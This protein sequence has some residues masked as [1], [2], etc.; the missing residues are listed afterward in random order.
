MEIRYVKYYLDSLELYE[1]IIIFFP[2]EIPMDVI[3]KWEKLFKPAF[4][5]L[6]IPTEIDITPSCEDPETI[7]IYLGDGW[8]IHICTST[9]DEWPFWSEKKFWLTENTTCV[10]MLDGGRF[11][12][13]TCD[14]YLFKGE[15]R[16][17][18][19]PKRRSL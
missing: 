14:D 13:W 19:Y 9:P 15:E 12:A 16:V 7:H 6:E 11:T 4:E 2:E 3:D 17:Y 18:I 5:E 8:E 10:I 1:G